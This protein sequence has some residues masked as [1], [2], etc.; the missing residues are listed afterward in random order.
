VVPQLATVY[1][2]GAADINHFHAAGGVQFLVG[3]LLDHGLMHADVRTVAGD[4]LER[5]REAP[6]LRD[7]ELVWR[8]VRPHSRDETVLRPVRAPFSGRRHPRAEG[9]ARRA[10]MKVSSVEQRVI[11]APARVRPPVGAA[12]RVQAASSIATSSSWCATRAW[13]ANGMPELHKLTPRS[14]L[15]DRGHRV[16][17]VTD[18]AGRAP[19][20]RSWRRSRTGPLELRDGDGARGRRRGPARR[21]R[22]P[23]RARPAGRPWTRRRARGGSCSRVP[24]LVGAPD[25]GASVFA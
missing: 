1:P 9:L 12:R 13:R 7:G 2:N 4:G 23:A 3:E 10:V 20:A 14:A 25:E 22:R 17:L 6:S 19:P 8:R 21:A 18:G 24:A 15:G 11:E 5:Y 16:A